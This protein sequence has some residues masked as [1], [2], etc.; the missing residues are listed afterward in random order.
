MTRVL[1]KTP[2]L[3]YYRKGIFFNYNIQYDRY[4]NKHTDSVNEYEGND[5]IVI[6]LNPYWF[7]RDEFYYDGHKANTI[8][9]LGVSFG[10]GY[11]Y[12]WK[13][14]KVKE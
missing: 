6:Q 4:Y 13:D 2:I 12:A 1:E 5:F 11:T 7:H 3:Q 14:L 10:K 8:T 9:I